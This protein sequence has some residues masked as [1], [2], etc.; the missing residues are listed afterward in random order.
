MNMLSYKGFM[1]RVEVDT[2]DALLIGH[3]AGINDIVG[4]HAETVPE[5]IEAFHDAVEDYLETCERA[6]K[7]PQKSYSGKLMF[8]V[9]PKIHQSAALAAEVAGKSLNQW[10]EEALRRQAE[11]QLTAV[12]AGSKAQAR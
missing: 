12:E 1:A 8:R 6:G 10:G 7:E 11:E 3:L 2:E 9:T 5:L 4:F